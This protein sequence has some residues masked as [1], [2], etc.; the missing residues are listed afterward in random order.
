MKK[1]ILST[2]I[3]SAGLFACNKAE[4][5]TQNA[6]DEV[7]TSVKEGYNRTYFDDGSRPGIV[8]ATFGCAGIGG[9]CVN[10]RVVPPNDV[11]M[12]AE[13]VSKGA[14][15]SSFAQ[16][17]NRLDTY[18]TADVV[19]QVISGEM[20]VE[21]VGAFSSTSEAYFLFSSNGEVVRAVPLK[22]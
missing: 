20:T 3:L 12:I 7:T 22:K 2:M 8:G 15:V 1:V 13:I 11:T 19:A 6:S 5:Q 16:F 17:N 18:F 9:S 14:P 4:V 10:G 21:V